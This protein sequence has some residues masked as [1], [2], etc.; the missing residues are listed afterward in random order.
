MGKLYSHTTSSVILPGCEGHATTLW[1]TYTEIGYT[2]D[3]L[4]WNEDSSACPGGWF[5]TCEILIVELWG[6]SFTR[7]ESNL[8]LPRINKQIHFSANS[9]TVIKGNELTI[10]NLS[11][12]RNLCVHFPLIHSSAICTALVAAPLRMLSDTIHR[13]N[14]FFTDSSRRMRPTNVSSLSCAQIGMGYI[15]SVGL[16]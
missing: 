12:Q 2:V 3:C 13:F 11:S 6:C 5:V 10:K 15:F 14:P 16:S 1:D 9:S 4:E 7:P 8:L